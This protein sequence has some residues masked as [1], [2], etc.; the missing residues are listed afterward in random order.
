MTLSEAAIDAAR[1]RHRLKVSDV[2]LHPGV[3]VKGAANSILRV[4][5]EFAVR[6]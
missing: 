5:H 2:F 4:N 6:Q 3:N 1:E